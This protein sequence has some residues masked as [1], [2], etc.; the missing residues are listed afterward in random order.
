MAITMYDLAG[1]EPARRPSPYCWRVRM[2]LAHMGCEV[3]T[4]PCRFLEKEKLPKSNDNKV[5]IIVDGHRVVHDS[6]AI[7][8]YIEEQYPAGPSLFGCETGRSLARFVQEWAETT[9]RNGLARLVLLDGVRH[10]DSADQIYF[11]NTREPRLGMTIDEL[12]AGR[13]GRLPEV[14]R[15]LDPLR[16]TLAHQ[17]FIAGSSPAY[18]DYLVFGEFQWA[19]SISD[20]EVLASDDPIRAWR[21]RMLDLFGGLARQALAYGD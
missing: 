7:A 1:A 6:W 20:F 18:A 14:R 11:R 5:P 9:V 16:R 19:R 15:S 21:G 10:L 3:E 17:N 2:A 12:V 8:A 13:E 4:V